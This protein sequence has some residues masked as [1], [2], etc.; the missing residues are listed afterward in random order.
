MMQWKEHALVRQWRL[1]SGER[2]RVIVAAL[3]ALT[4]V[5]AWQLAWEP[6]QARLQQAGQALAREQAL[7]DHLQRVSAGPARMQEAWPV[8]TPA[9]LSER[10]QAAGVRITGLETRAQQV[11]VS[12]EGSPAVMFAW[13][14]ALEREGGRVRDM[15]LQVMDDQL[16]ARVSLELDEA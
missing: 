6:G 7:A 13:L 1:I 16:Q 5:A 9:R 10:A 2:R 3:W 11:D 12:F 14:H 8:L 4:L 15:Q